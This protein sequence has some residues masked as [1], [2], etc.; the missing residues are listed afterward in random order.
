MTRAPAACLRPLSS[1]QTHLSCN[2]PRVSGSLLA[3]ARVHQGCQP[4]CQHMLLYDQENP[5]DQAQVAASLEAG[6]R[7]G[8]AKI[9]RQRCIKITDV[10]RCQAGLSILL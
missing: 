7:R 5:P 3:P 10:L 2:I 6:V 8:V 9:G 1:W 4:G